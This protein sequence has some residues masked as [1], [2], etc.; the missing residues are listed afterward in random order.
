MHAPANPAELLD[1]RRVSSTSHPAPAVAAEQPP[2]TALRPYQA[3]A[4]QAI[5]TGLIDGGLGQLHAACGSGKSLMIQRSAERCVPDS[6][7][8]AVLVP[9]LSLAAQT[10][11]SWRRHA[12]RPV[13][14]VLAVCSDDTVID[15]PAHL[16]DV[17]A[18]VSLSTDEITS[19]L[20]RPAHGLSLIVCTYISAERLAEAVRQAGKPL[21]FLALDEAH[22]LTGRPDFTTRRVVDRTWLPAVRRLYATATPRVDTR[23]SDDPSAPAALS[24]DDTGAFGAVLYSYPFSRAIA[25]G[26]LE[27]YRVVVVGI[28][29]SEART[30]L[31]DQQTEYVGRIGGPSLQTLVAQTALARAREQFGVRRVISFQYRVDAAA[32]FTKTLPAT[33]KRLPGGHASGLTAR[34]VHGGMDHRTRAR[35]LDYL[36]HPAANGWTVI[37]NARCLGEGV[38][39][40]AVDAVLFGHPKSSEV[41][42]VQAVGRALRPHP[43][44]PGPS[45]LIIPLIIPDQDGEIGDLD[46]GDYATLWRVVR[47]LRAHDEPLGSALDLQR[48]ELHASNP[49]LPGK[50]TVLLPDGTPE[51]VMA[52]LT[53]LLVQKTTSAWWEGYTQASRYASDNGD[54]LVHV[55]YR[56]PDEFGLG[57]WVTSARHAR[58]KGWLP[59]DRVRA[60]EN[61]G[62]EWEPGRAQQQAVIADLRDHHTRYGRL[63]TGHGEETFAASRSGIKNARMWLTDRRAEHQRGDLDSWIA[64]E[65]ETMGMQWGDRPA[66]A[67][68][69]GI[70]AATSH[71]RR[72][73]HL[74]VGKEQT[75]DG[76]P[77][78]AW[79]HTQRQKY[80]N[81]HLSAEQIEELEGLGIVWAPREAQFQTGLALARAYAEEHGSL[82]VPQKCATDD[83][84]LGSWIAEQRRNHKAGRLPEHRRQALEELGMNWETSA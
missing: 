43:D 44:A 46:A 6:A 60:L 22:H 13:T 75:E 9:S 20:S 2:A 61:I 18:E 69:L 79:L 68:R 12:T 52:Q 25:E 48:S 16:G 24:M 57:T 11:A 29:D 73:G 77:L 72:T 27:D 58:R 35:I 53:L 80:R 54:L 8:V 10:A 84:K 67:W 74:R 47:A 21:D 78:G 4:V 3:E 40:P 23:Q 17:D 62:I 83:F 71:H 49:G 66:R 45:T 28:P 37:S 14:R 30:M 32:E 36:H 1:Q 26:Y 34:H 59:A 70:E 51:Q 33:L 39:V 5:T 65:L 42:I 82:A 38:D 31:A 55:A 15:A 41:D 56:T 50:I 63:P 19:W 7:V 81:S 64:A 76:Y